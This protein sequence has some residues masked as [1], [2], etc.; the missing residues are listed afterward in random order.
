MEY[1]KTNTI[2][3]GNEKANSNAI[4]ATCG[5]LLIISGIILSQACH[6]FGQNMGM[7]FLPMHIPIL[8]AGF[9]LGPYYGIAVAL[10]TP[11]LS[12]VMTGMPAVPK[13]YF[14]LVELAF[15]GIITGIMIKKYNIYISIITAMIAG[16]LF[17]GIALIIGV[18][19][20]NI[21]APF[22]SQ[23]AFISTIITGMPG[24]AV[25]ILLIP[26]LV[27]LIQKRVSFFEK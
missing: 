18:N 8:M 23:A 14:M 1:N 21:H 13:L 17:Y 5:F 9:L 2:V 16:R 12:F 20:F 25:Q 6:A 3:K 27:K 4:K 22:A 10:T 24:I 15:Y 11:V 7:T 26:Q 19:M